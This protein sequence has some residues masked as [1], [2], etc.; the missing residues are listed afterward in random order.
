MSSCIIRDMEKPA[1]CIVCDFVKYFS[2]GSNYC[3]RM[4]RPINR[5]GLRYSP[6]DW[7]P[8]TALPETHGDLID[9]DAAQESLR[10][11]MVMTG[12]QSA[13]LE[14]IR[15]FYVPTIIPEERGVANVKADD[16]KRSDV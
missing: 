12:Y 16:S 1:C 13:A 11:G 15:E 6:P 3:D 7:C 4:K 2:D 8:I 10:T 9:R 14:C 5:V